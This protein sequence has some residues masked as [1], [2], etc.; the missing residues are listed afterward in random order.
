MGNI[1]DY[2]RD[3]RVSFEEKPFCE[4]DSLILCQLSN[5]QLSTV[6]DAEHEITIRRLAEE[7]D[8][9]ALYHDAWVAGKTRRLLLLL[10]ENPRF[11]NM[12]LR[13]FHEEYDARRETQFAAVTFTFYD[14]S[15]LAFRGTDMTF[16]GWKEDFNMAHTFPVPAQ[17]A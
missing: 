12:R 14:I 5:L 10:A 1:L 11:S 2:A 7:H 15:Y 6:C 8:T 4:V 9:P 3:I 16:I 13:F 17:A